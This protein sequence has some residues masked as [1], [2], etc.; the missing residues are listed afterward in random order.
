MD[1]GERQRG[2]RDRGC[3]RWGCIDILH[4][5]VGFSL[6][7]GDAVMEDITSEAFDLVTTVN[8]RGMVMTCKHVLPIMRAQRSGVICGYSG[9]E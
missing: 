8:L 6:A 7:G 9:H 1:R 2:I 3:A 5:N 4:N